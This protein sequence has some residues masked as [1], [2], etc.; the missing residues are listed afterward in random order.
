MAA[1]MADE[2]ATTLGRG[3]TPRAYNTTMSTAIDCRPLAPSH[4]KSS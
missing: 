1:Q 4:E 3:V 2:A